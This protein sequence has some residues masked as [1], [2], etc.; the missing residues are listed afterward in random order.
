[1]AIRLRL[2]VVSVIGLILAQWSCS[3]TSLGAAKPNV[4]FIMSDDAAY[5]DFGFSAALNGRTTQIETPNLDALAQ[6]SIVAS[7]A[8]VASPLCSPT[9]AG[10]LTGLY[11]Q[12]FGYEDNLANTFAT[13]GTQGL[14]E[15]QITIA[16][17]LK[18]LGYTTGIVGKWHEGFVDG[19]NRPL[20][21][22]FDEFYGL[23]GGGRSYWAQFSQEQGIWKN[24][25]FYESQHHNPVNKD[26]SQFN[27]N[28]HR[29]LTDALGDEAADFIDRHAQDE[30]PFFLYL[31]MTAP[32][33]PWDAKQADLDRFAHI[34]DPARRAIAA[35]TYAMDRAVG[36]VVDSLQSNGID[37][38][39]IV[40][41]TNDNGAVS[42]INN[43][44]F[45]GHKG[46]TWEGGIRVPFTI[47]GPGL[48]PGV[49]SGPITMFDM[50]PTL[51][52]AAGG[53]VSQF[54][55]DGYDVMPLLKGEQTDDPHDV[56]FW[57]SMDSWAV[58]KGDWKLG[59]MFTG[60]PGRFLHNIKNDPAETNFLLSQYPLIVADLMRELTNWEA[61]LAKPKWGSIGA[62]N[63]NV[64]DHFVFRNDLAASNNWNATGVWRQAGTTTN[65]TM[66]PADAYANAILEFGVR[67]D[68]DYT[69]V[70]NMTRLTKRTFM[71]NQLRLTG[72]FEGVDHR[73]GTISGNKVL[74]VRSQAGELPQIRLDATS[75]GTTSTFNFHL[76]NELQLLHDLEITGDGTQNFVINGQIRDYYESEAPNITLPH[77]VTKLGTSRVTLTAENT[78]GGSLSILGGEV[79]IDGPSAAVN[80]PS[81]IYI[82]SGGGLTLNNGT[83]S[84]PAIDNSNGGF[85]DFNGGLLKTSN[86]VGS[87]VNKGGV[88][89]PGASPALTRITGHFV[90]LAGSLQI[91][92][93]GTA[94][95]TQ[96]D[97]LLV[98]GEAFLGGTL[99]V[100]LM[101]GFQPGLG[102]AFQFLTAAGGLHD[103]FAN[104]LL[105]ELTG[106]W[107]WNLLYGP[108][109]V[110]LYV[111]PA[112]GIGDVL[113]GDYNQNG[114]VDAADYT[115][116]R[117][118][119]DNSQGVSPGSAADGSFD[120]Q[121]TAADYAVWKSMFGF[122]RATGGQASYTAVPE[123]LSAMLLAI[124][125]ALAGCLSDNRCRRRAR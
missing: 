33:K 4:V 125:M 73:Q 17:R 66:K 68:S 98:G 117:D 41:F 62:L 13:A 14:N 88:F 40:I 85:L 104:A 8:Y 1:M 119:V 101:P 86:V 59:I 111:G 32:H 115:V 123:P 38:N 89:A 95:G 114:I 116:W 44:P 105:P 65:A 70:N 109:S 69:A 50:L 28:N 121:I 27:S 80:G 47:K 7:Q 107:T 64:F 83:I 100:V 30:N 110:V 74:F 90:Q 75:S 46:T 18:P 84:V 42:Y 24:N 108:N 22:G 9:R 99:D 35:M 39:T 71:L 31:S 19:F 12:R 26:P 72:S 58:R 6:R 118:L 87:L 43:P 5:S 78:F 94:P 2:R 124:G 56:M 37:E 76:N 91:E 23:L 60:A 96:F 36:K 45:K 102:T 54:P 3:L 97:T 51:V 15:Q 92:L 16:Q 77:N 63:Q 11:Q 93:G 57:R 103:T 122:A 48:Q 10:L 82:G 49:Y 21:K 120:G 67:D 25:Q 52:T 20:D 81:S 112:G 53:D 61:Q 113:P 34:S 55:T 79:V 29:Y 106:G